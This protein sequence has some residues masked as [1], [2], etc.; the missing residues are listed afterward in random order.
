MRSYA[1]AL[2]GRFIFG[3]GGESLTV[4]TSTLEATWFMG[5]ELS[6]AI[7]VDYSMAN[8]AAF[9]NDS[10]EPWMYDIK[11]SLPYVFWVGLLLCLFS[12]GATLVVYFLDGKRV[13]SEKKNGLD[14][15]NQTF[16]LS[17]ALKFKW[18]FWVLSLAI[19]F[20]TLIWVLFNNMASE[21]FQLRFGFSLQTTGTLIGLE[22]LII[23]CS[24]P[25]LGLLLDRIGH[26]IE[27]GNSETLIVHFRLT[28]KFRL[29]S[30]SYTFLWTLLHVLYSQDSA[31][32][33]DIDTFVR[34]G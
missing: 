34:N 11:N 3:L 20:S 9:A 21:F 27:F 30:Y 32:S 17:D 12:F 28:I 10:L 19:A 1:I 13:R 22:A 4:A 15:E 24:A 14:K 16:H 2:L 29:C 25:F 23:G 26:R 5:K 18:D 8:F 7:A 33:Y 6:F 31:G